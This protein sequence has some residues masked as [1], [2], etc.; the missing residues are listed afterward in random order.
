MCVTDSLKRRLAGFKNDLNLLPK[1]EEPPSTVLQII[2]DNQQEQD[3]QRLLF[4]YLSPDG[5]HGL[6][7]AL[8]EH[9]LSAL[10]ERSDLDFTFSRFDLA[11]VQ[12]EQEVTIS[13][14]R[15]PDAVIWASEDWFI[16]WEL[17][18]DASE[19]EDQTQD[20]VITDA[21]QSIN[22]EK[23]D[24]PTDSHHYI[25]LAPDDTLPGADEF[26][27]VSWNWIAE[28]I[29]MFLAE[30]HGEYPARTIA[31]LEMFSG[32]IRSELTMTKYKENRREKI[33]LYLDYY[34]EISEVQQAFERQWETFAETWG[35]QLAQSVDTATIVDTFDVPNEYV[36]VELEIENG[37]RLLWT[38]RQ[39][40]SDWSWVFPREWWTRLDDRE[41]ISDPS[42]P[43]AR[44]GFLHRLDGNR[45]EVL[46]DHN[47]ICYLRNAPASNEAFYDGFAR[48]FNND[49]NIPRLLPDLTSR[50]G[51]KSN[52]LQ[53][54]YDINVESHDDFFGAYIATLS[55]ALNDH[56]ISNPELVNRIDRLYNQ[57]VEEDT[58]F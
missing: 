45:D 37:D 47:L 26:V 5:P 38:F 54:T 50:P 24:V 18:V 2:R 1:A 17:K 34:N 52:V 46:R 43:Q 10:S 21:F 56:V 13:N 30:S 25:Y 3:W 28:E 32:T 4:H 27:P 20:Y 29:Q 49:E 6:D 19:G 36:P 39:G 44:V 55:R 58:S 57:T 35:T 48:R 11:D 31:Q 23:E 41:P 16:C 53:A 12:I 42:T 15:R 14:G 33:E 40:H 9:L 22:L 7:Y 8:L 51:V